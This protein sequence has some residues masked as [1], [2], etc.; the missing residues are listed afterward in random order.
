M[1]PLAFTFLVTRAANASAPVG[2]TTIFMRSQSQ[3]IAGSS[4][5]SVTVA[6]SFT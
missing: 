1:R 3:N 6:I 4:S 5:S 2:S